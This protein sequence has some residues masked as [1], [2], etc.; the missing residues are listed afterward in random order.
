MNQSKINEVINRLSSDE[1]ERQDLW[2]A[3]LSGLD[4]L[5]PGILLKTSEDSALKKNIWYI[6]QDPT[7]KIHEVMDKFSELER[8]IM[9]CLMVGLS[10]SEI[11]VYKGISEVRVRQIIATIRY[12]KSWQEVHNGS[13]E[14][15]HGPGKIWSK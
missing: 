9:F 3:H 11:S 5:S 12:N 6:L 8:S 14:E 1:D 10:V 13:K 2:V 15:P 4:V 7:S